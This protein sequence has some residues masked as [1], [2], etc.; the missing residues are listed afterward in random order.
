MCVC[1]ELSNARVCIVHIILVLVI[2]IVGG[3][4][5]VLLIIIVGVG[6]FNVC[7]F[8]TPNL[9]PHKH[10]TTESN[11]SLQNSPSA[12]IGMIKWLEDCNSNEFFMFNKTD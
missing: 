6:V 4:I 12:M 10:F 3:F 8:Y 2:I 11:N 7:W 9:S 5:V 1:V